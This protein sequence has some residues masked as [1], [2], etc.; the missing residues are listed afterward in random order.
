MSDGEKKLEARSNAP[1]SHNNAF[2]EAAIEDRANR[3][4]EERRYF[5]LPKN[6]HASNGV[7]DLDGD[8]SFISE[9]ETEAVAPEFSEESMALAFTKMHTGRFLFVEKFGRWLYWDECKWVDDQKLRAF[10]AVRRICRDTA[11]TVNEPGLSRRIASYKTAYAV[12]RLARTEMAAS[13]DQWDTDLWL[14]NT[15]NGVINLRDGSIRESL[16][17]DY[18]TKAT[19][20]SPGGSCPRFLQ[21]MNEI[22]DGDQELIAYIQR[23]FGLCLTGITRDDAVFFGY[24]SGG[25]GKSLLMRVM[26]EILGDYHTVSSVE[27]FAV[28]K[29]ERHLTEVARLRGARLVTVSETENGRQWAEARLKEMTGGTPVAANFMR[30]DQFEYVPQFKPFITGNNKPNLASATESMRRRF[31][32]IPFNVTFSGSRRDNLLH[33]KLV[34]EYPGILAWAVEGCAQWQVMGLQPPR[35]VSEAINALNQSNFRDANTQH[36]PMVLPTKAPLSYGAAPSP[37]RIAT[38]RDDLLPSSVFQSGQTFSP[39]T[40]Q[41]KHRWSLGD[42]NPIGKA[43]AE[44]QQLTLPQS[45]LPTAPAGFA[46]MQ[47]P[48]QLLGTDITKQFQP[49][50]L[51]PSLGMPRTGIT[52][53]DM[54]AFNQPGM[55]GDRD[56]MGAQPQGFGTINLPMN[57]NEEPMQE[58]PSMHP[59]M[60]PEM[61]TAPT[62]TPAQTAQPSPTAKPASGQKYWG[63]Y[64]DVENNS[65]GDMIDEMAGDKRTA[66]APG[67]ADTPMGKFQGE[68]GDL[69]S[70][71][72]MAGYKPEPAGNDAGGFDLGGLL[73][74]FASGGVV[75]RR[76]ADGGSDFDPIEGFGQL[77][78]DVGEGA[79]NLFGGIGDALS[80]AGQS[81]GNLTDGEN[82]SAQ[83][84]PTTQTQPKQEPQQQPSQGNDGGLFGGGGFT[85]SPIQTALLTAG[86][87]TMASDRVNPL[88]AIGEGGLAGV[89]AYGE[90]KA[91][92]D[93]MQEQKAAAERSREF[94]RRLNGD[95][96]P[97]E[98]TESQPTETNPAEPVVTPT[99]TTSPSPNAQPAV[100]PATSPT[101]TPVTAPK[102][103]APQLTAP[104]PA[105]APQA[106]PQQP[107]G[108]SQESYNKQ[109]S[110]IENDIV[111]LA[112]LKSGAPDA[113]SRQAVDARIGAL[114]VQMQSLDRKYAD[115]QRR[116]RVLDKSEYP[117]YGIPSDYVGPVQVNGSGHI[118][119][120]GGQYQPDPF[121][122]K[123]KEQAAETF[124]NYVQAGDAA[125]STQGL[126]DIAEELSKT[127]DTGV[128][129]VLQKKLNQ[130]GFNVGPNAD[131]IAALNSIY[132]RITPTLRVPGSGA[133]SDYDAR[134]F[135]S[136]LPSLRN[137]AEGNQLIFDTA[138]SINA[139]NM[140]R[141]NIAMQ[142]QSG[143]IS[144]AEA[145]RKIRELPD[146]FARF[147]SYAEQHPNATPEQQAPTMPQQ[148]DTI[149]R[150][151]V[152]YSWD[153]ASQKYK[154]VRQ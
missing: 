109:R 142:A 106:V 69:G 82:V 94:I 5:E 46:P 71:F 36:N 53:L 131:K 32:L 123:S 67:K 113:A 150:N 72:D 143:E 10:N 138:R 4:K 146:P 8:I 78:N 84:A 76:F 140:E 25:N 1:T 134:N 48:G 15:P 35:A 149:E 154:R 145:Q 11:K 59:N 7:D 127:A 91:Y 37:V 56:L 99:Q 27:T 73:P 3:A 96:A 112:R 90:A 68:Q 144:L 60:G 81:F 92:D 83:G 98:T 58:T 119:M 18:I 43:H 55:A 6:I 124:N 61:P 152:S 39:V 64:R 38:S 132:S 137:T 87:R 29:H 117:K 45:I 30:Q 26:G 141:A 85:W 42:L 114:K 28:N 79:G 128:P 104:T 16:P 74:E 65:F 47:G 40:Q 34:E 22:F 108:V 86:L 125:R 100:S 120:P 105:P 88:Q 63:D 77:L 66:S 23:V 41:P 122:K 110:A 24:G 13:T 101:T 70:V 44:E 111:R 52:G 129:A 147:K 62:P 103:N 20:V 54:E 135:E 136:S 126:L 75:R 17:T 93:A 116:V 80:G 33:D 102:E 89:Q 107:V 153:A 31:N 9:T 57:S 148:G 130:F 19:T 49:N 51:Q 95:D 118:S 121:V 21:F 97:S 151:G 12:E 133:T 50:A 115:E 14:L 2:R 139:Y